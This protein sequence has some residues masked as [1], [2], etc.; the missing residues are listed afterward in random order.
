MYEFLPE[1]VVV[2][3]PTL[4]LVFIGFVVEKHYVSRVTTFTNSLALV[5]F[6]LTVVDVGGW[7]LRI[8][9]N[10]GLLLGVIGF[11]SYIKQESLPHDYYMLSHIGY[12][13]FFV[14]SILLY[15]H[16][17][18]FLGLVNIPLPL[19]LFAGAF[20][21]FNLMLLDE[22]DQI[23]Y[24]GAAPY[25]VVD[26]IKS[27]DIRVPDGRGGSMMVPLRRWFD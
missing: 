2:L 25:E 24:T 19:W 21:I 3:L 27:Y 12:G 8:H 11:L 23:F 26:F 20:F 17:Q 13:S 10:I 22:S 1:S 4:S 14:G 6:Y 15:P 16:A 7:L 9:A 5:V 18:W